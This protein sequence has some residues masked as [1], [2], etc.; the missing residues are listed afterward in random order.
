M[1]RIERYC[2]IAN[3][4]KFNIFFSIMIIIEKLFEYIKMIRNKKKN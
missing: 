2:V 1:N 4:D 3:M